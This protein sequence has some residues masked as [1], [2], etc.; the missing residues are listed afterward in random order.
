MW[1]VATARIGGK[2]TPCLRLRG[3]RYPFPS[4]A[5]GLPETASGLFADWA[6]ATARFDRSVGEI[7]LGKRRPMWVNEVGAELLA[8]LLYPG[9]ILC[10]GANYY[11]HMAEMGFPGVKKE[12]GH[13]RDDARPVRAGNQQPPDIAFRAVCCWRRR[14]TRGVP[15]RRPVVG[16]HGT[17]VRHPARYASA[18]A[19]ATLS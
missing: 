3:R 8:P 1:A 12:T 15:P 11:D 6:A 5:T 9:K 13:G 16:L 14:R 19:S 4:L 18:I 10:A 17:S 2:A 7:E